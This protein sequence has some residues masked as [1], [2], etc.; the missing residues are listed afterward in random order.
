MKDTLKWAAKFSAL[1]SLALR[2]VVAH[3]GLFHNPLRHIH[4]ALNASIA[5]RR[6]WS[7]FSKRRLSVHFVV[8]TTKPATL[9]LPGQFGSRSG[10]CLRR[11]IRDGLSRSIRYVSTERLLKAKWPGI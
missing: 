5:A 3:F 7:E 2:S 1:V 9:I 6:S 10:P 4:Q 8:F 11:V